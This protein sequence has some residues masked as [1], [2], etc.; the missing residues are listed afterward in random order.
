MQ[1]N[2]YLEATKERNVER[3]PLSME[4]PNPRSET[5]DYSRYQRFTIEKEDHLAIVRLNRP[6]KRNAIDHQFHV[7]FQ[8]LFVDLVDDE[9][10]FA[11]LL[12]ATGETFSVGGDVKGMK[13]RPAG[14]VVADP[15]AVLE[16]GGARRILYNL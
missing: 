6:E 10:V 8:T 11:I 9:E 14:D 7:E 16:P 5:M 1:F 12:T 4:A 13:D 2:A 15:D 3:A